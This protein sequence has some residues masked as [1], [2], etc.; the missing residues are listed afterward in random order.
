[1]RHQPAHHYLRIYRI[2]LAMAEG[3]TT[4]PK[5]EYVTF[6]RDLITR[7]EPLDPGTPIRVETGDGI[8]RFKNATT[9]ECLAQTSMVTDI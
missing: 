7:L 8:A 6:M 1:M 3:G 2:R 9:G 5:P 4:Q